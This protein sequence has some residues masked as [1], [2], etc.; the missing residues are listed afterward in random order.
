MAKLLN[1]PRH[2]LKR[3]AHSWHHLDRIDFDGGT[4]Q[5]HRWTSFGNLQHKDTTTSY[6]TSLE[7]LYEITDVVLVICAVVFIISSVA[8][9]MLWVCGLIWMDLL[10]KLILSIEQL[11]QRNKIFPK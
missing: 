5:E 2:Q 8:S 10:E 7:L 6:S 3:E 1:V 4:L 11:E 9:I